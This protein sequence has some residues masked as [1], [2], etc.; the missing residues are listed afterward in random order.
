MSAQGC[1]HS[2]FNISEKLGTM[3]V[4]N[5]SQLWCIHLMYLAETA[6]SLPNIHSLIL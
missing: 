4:S 5:N 3:Q 2:V 1:Y 6:R